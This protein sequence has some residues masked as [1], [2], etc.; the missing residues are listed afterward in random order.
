MRLETGGILNRAGSRDLKA[1]G[2]E[3]V[4]A[5][6]VSSVADRG[7]LEAALDYARDG[8]VLEV[9]KLDHLS[10]QHP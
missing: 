4:F 7:Q 1:A 6:Q 8:D 3:K 5:E 9:T 2:V 10:R